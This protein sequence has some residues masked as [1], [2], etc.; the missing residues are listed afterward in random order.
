MGIR[1][2]T[3]STLSLFEELTSKHKN[4]IRKGFTGYP[5][6]PLF[7]R[8]KIDKSLEYKMPAW[9]DDFIIATRSTAEQ[10][11][12]QVS[13]VLEKHEKAVYKASKEKSKVLRNEVNWLEFRI[14]KNGITPLREKTEAIRK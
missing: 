2:L 5:M 6:C 14:T 9:Q 11:M 1:K 13:L 7:S 3:D 10:H 8:K 12:T 4:N